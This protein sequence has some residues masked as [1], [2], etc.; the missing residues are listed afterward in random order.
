MSRL[1]ENKQDEAVSNGKV[2]KES[3]IALCAQ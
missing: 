2:S 3:G 1:D